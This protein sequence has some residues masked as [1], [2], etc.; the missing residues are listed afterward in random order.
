MFLVMI[1]IISLTVSN[2][3]KGIFCYLK[4]TGQGRFFTPRK[5]AMLSQKTEPGGSIVVLVYF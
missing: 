1:L 5:S 2:S 4:N 3:P